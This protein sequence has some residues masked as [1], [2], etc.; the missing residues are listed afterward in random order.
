MSLTPETYERIATAVFIEMALAGVTTVGEFHYVHHQEGGDPYDDH[1]EMGHA[2]IRAARTAGIRICLL[3][4]GYFTAGFGVPDLSP[5]QQRFSDVSPDEWVERVADLSETYADATDVNVGLAPHSVRAA[6][7][8]ALRTVAERRDPKAPLH[9]H[10]S[11]QPAENR[12][13]MQATGMTPTALL[14]DCGLLGRA[15]TLV[16]ATHLSGDDIELIGGTS[17]RVCYCATTERDL[18]DGIGPAAALSAAGAGFCVGSDSHAIIDIF[19]EARGIELHQRLA[20]GRRGLFSPAELLTTATTGGSGALGFVG[21]LHPGAPADFTVIDIDSPRLAGFHIRHGLDTVVYAATRADV[22]DV[23]VAGRRIVADGSHPG[24]EQA[25][26]ALA[27][28]V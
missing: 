27:E 1:N 21:G 9:V 24:W 7:V 28:S 16:H 17:C 2:L 23:F 10:V 25:R 19:E 3:D 13:C 18:G 14:H 5:V 12:D 4:A 11:E 20:T 22:R 8:E 26:N 6:P 15:T